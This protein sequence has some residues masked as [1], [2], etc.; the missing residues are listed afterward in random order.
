[1]GLDYSGE[2][3]GSA[4]ERLYSL[5]LARANPVVDD[6]TFRLVARVDPDHRHVLIRFVDKAMRLSLGNQR[7]ITTAERVTSAGD[8]TRRTALND[9]DGLIVE[10][11]VAR[12]RSSRS[13]P[14]VSATDSLRAKPLRK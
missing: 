13:K 5:P 11:R 10:V 7:G 2:K 12:Q 4:A 9:G 8:K 14:T 1:M 3:G 6:H